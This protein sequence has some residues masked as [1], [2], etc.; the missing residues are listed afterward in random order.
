VPGGPQWPSFVRGRR[1]YC[2]VAA[3]R[4]GVS[5]AVVTYVAAREG[6]AGQGRCSVVDIQVLRRAVASPIGGLHRAPA[7]PPKNGIFY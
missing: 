4:E 7:Y 2:D 1:R 3:A 6:V 5:D